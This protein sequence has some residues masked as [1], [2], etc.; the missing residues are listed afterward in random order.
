ME[1]T[2]AI[3]LPKA[4]RHEINLGYLDPLTIDPAEYEN[5]EDEGILY[6][7]VQKHTLKDILYLMRLYCTT[8]KVIANRVVT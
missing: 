7:C 8:I 2:C 1:V 5:R 3:A 4:L 6:A